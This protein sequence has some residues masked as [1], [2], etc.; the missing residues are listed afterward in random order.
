MGSFDKTDSCG[1]ARPVG[2]HVMS[3][4]S[5]NRTQH[6]VMAC[7]ASFATLLSLTSSSS[8]IFPFL[9]EAWQK[10]PGNPAIPGHCHL[11]ALICWSPRV[12]A[13]LCCFCS[14]EFGDWSVEVLIQLNWTAGMLMNGD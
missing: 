6:S 1:E 14:F 4:G 9:R 13:G 11:H 12:S 5:I 3:G 7:I 2:E 10:T 8:L